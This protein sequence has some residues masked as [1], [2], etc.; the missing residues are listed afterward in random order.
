M[1]IYYNLHSEN[2]SEN[3]ASLNL[4]LMSKR[5]QKGATNPQIS[6]TITPKNLKFD[7][8]VPFGFEVLTEKGFYEIQTI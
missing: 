2:L 3:I 6:K 7:T 5:N 8:N 4:L 1:K